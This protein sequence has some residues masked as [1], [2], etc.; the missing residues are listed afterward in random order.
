MFNIILVVMSAKL[1]TIYRQHMAIVIHNTLE[2]EAG[3]PLLTN[4]MIMIAH[5]AITPLHMDHRPK[6][7]WHIENL[8]IRIENLQI[9][10]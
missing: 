4:C 9:C 2:P 6:S 10:I 3:I 7:M 5:G 8:Q 1:G